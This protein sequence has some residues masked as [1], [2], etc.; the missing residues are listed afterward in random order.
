MNPN[1]F[2]KV[3]L[4]RLSSPER[5]DLAWKVTN[6]KEWMALLGI[7]FLIGAATVWGFKGSLATKV[8][9]QGVIIHRGGVV[10]IVAPGT[11]QVVRVAVARRR[12]RPRQPGDRRDC[13]AGSD[14]AH[15]SHAGRARRREAGAR[16]T[17]AR[18]NRQ[19]ESATRSSRPSARQR[20]ARN[21]RTRRPDQ[22]RER[23]D[24]GG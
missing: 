22:N 5:L 12:Q 10:N 24:S 17:T 16:K 1:I 6:P 18:E 9:A 11:G 19:R 14:G 3:S 20:G 4:E 8:M 7:F 2:R 23:A 21:R 15:Q 13:P